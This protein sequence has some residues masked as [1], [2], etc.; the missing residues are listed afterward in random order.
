MKT[1]VSDV[2]D[3]KKMTRLIKMLRRCYRPRKFEETC[4]DSKK[5]FNGRVY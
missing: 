3:V 5:M 4:L 1:K 2:D